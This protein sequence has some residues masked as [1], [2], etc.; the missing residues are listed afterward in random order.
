MI[1]GTG[2][3]SNYGS[4][5]NNC[6]RNQMPYKV[7]IDGINDVQLY[8]N[9]GGIKP[10]SI[11]YQLIHTCG[12]FAGLVESLSPPDFVIGQRSDNYWYGVFKNFSNPVNP[13]SCFV[14]GVTLT[15]NEVEQIYFSDEYCVENCRDLT[16]IKGCYG[17]L[18]SQ[19]SFDRQGIY[20]G[21]HSGEDSAM[22]DV[23]VKY[24]H[25]VKLRDAEL[26]LSALKKTFKQGRTRNFRTETEDIYEFLCEFV[27]EWFV[28]E[29]G[30]VFDRGEIY[31]DDTKYLVEGVQFE[32]IEPC[33]RIWKPVATLKESYYQSFS[34]ESDPCAPLPETCCLPSAI[35]AAV[36]YPES[37]ELCC[38]PQIIS[39]SV[40]EES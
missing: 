34:C 26:S 21:V 4:Y 31:F 40:F 17:N 13:L 8:I 15:I 28:R 1:P 30:Q 32:K 9:I 29:I 7:P 39:A 3:I 18:D 20:F 14:I 12:E 38:D 25:K 27:P 36:D 19:I 35:N 23:S 22:G 33:K 16:E 2:T 6:Q 5:I 24:E 11:E 37:G 10:E